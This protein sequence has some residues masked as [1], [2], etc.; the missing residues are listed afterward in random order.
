MIVAPAAMAER[1]RHLATQARQPVPHYE[2]REV[3][4]NYR[5]SNL[6]AALGDAQLSGLDSR[7]ERRRSIRYRYE[8]ELSETDGIVSF[9]P[10]AEY[11][12]PNSWLTVAQLADDRVAQICKLMGQRGV[13]VRRAWKPMHMQPVFESHEAHLK[14]VSEEIFATGL[15]LPS[16]SSLTEEEQ[17]YVIDSLK[18]SLLEGQT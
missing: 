6:L 1:A 17:R 4:Y 13:E 7:I 11:G 15:C 12:E 18:E 10:I 16:G 2:H 14:G 5:M 8:A 3:G 9:M